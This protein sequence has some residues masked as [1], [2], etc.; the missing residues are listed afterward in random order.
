MVS[1]WKELEKI[2][3]KRVDVLFRTALELMTD[4][5][6]WMEFEIQKISVRSIGPKEVRESLAEFMDR[7]MVALPKE[8]LEIECVK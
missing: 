2:K 5:N 7:E 8:A 3:S 4:E 6:P 1:T